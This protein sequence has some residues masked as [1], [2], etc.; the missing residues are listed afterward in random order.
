MNL[1]SKSVT[2]GGIRFILFYDDI[3]YSDP[4]EQKIML[5]NPMCDAE[6]LTRE[7]GFKL[8]KIENSIIRLLE[9]S[10]LDLFPTKIMSKSSCVFS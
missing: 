5:F 9:N 10:S 4:E 8:L 2:H 3:I 7:K 1:E 6:E